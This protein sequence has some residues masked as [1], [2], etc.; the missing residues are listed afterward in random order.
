MEILMGAFGLLLPMFLGLVAVVGAMS[1]SQIPERTEA[2]KAGDAGQ[3]ISGCLMI[4]VAGGLFLAAL[5]V[6]VLVTF[7]V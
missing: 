4:I 6:F 3:I 2:E 1:G 7:A 5:F